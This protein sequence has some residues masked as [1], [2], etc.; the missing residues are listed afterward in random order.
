MLKHTLYTHHKPDMPN[1]VISVLVKNNKNVDISFSTD[2]I[3]NVASMSKDCKTDQDKC[4]RKEKQ[5]NKNKQKQTK[6]P[7]QDGR[8]SAKVTR[9]RRRCTVE[10]FLRVRVLRHSF[11]EG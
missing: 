8:K 4:V 1:H 11:L 7:K 6:E 2:E 10:S 5:A 9:A 3:Q